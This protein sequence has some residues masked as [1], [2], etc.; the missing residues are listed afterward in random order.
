LSAAAGT[1][2]LRQT[3]GTVDLSYAFHFARV[4]VHPLVALGAGV[5]HIRVDGRADPPYVGEHHDLVTA[6]I[7]AGGGL[8]LRITPKLRAQAALDVLTLLPEPFVTI[9]GVEVGR[10]G[11]PAF[12][13]SIG[14]AAVF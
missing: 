10:A 5:Y 4:R 13:P 14:F 8:G 11:R 6:A 12:L 1:V 7:S 9:A 2:A 3:V